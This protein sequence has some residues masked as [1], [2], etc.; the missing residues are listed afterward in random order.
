MG[1]VWKSMGRMT[2][3]AGVILCVFIVAGLVAPQDSRSA[4]L[5]DIPVTV[6]Q[7]DGEELHLLASGDEFNN[8]LHDADHY[9]VLQDL[10]T[11]YYVYAVEGADGDVAPSI[12]QVGKVNPAAVGLKQ[13][14]KRS[15]KKIQERIYER[16]GSVSKGSPLQ[17]QL[18][19]KAPQ[20][21][22]INNLVIF[23]RFSDSPAFSHNI[24]YYKDMFNSNSSGVNSMK[25]YYREA[26][27]NQ[28]AINTTFYPAP[29]GTTIQ[30]YTDSHARNYYQKYHAVTNP[31]GYRNGAQRTT[32]EHTLLKN[33]VEAVRDQV[34]SDLII[35]GDND[36]KVDNVCFIIQGSP[37]GWNELLWPHMWSLYSYD[38]MINNKQ[39]STF[40]F[41][42]ETAT[43]AS[44]VGVLAHEMFHSLGAPD[45]YQYNENAV[46]SPASQWDL[47]D[48][49]LNPPQHMTA[50]M[51]M[52]YGK[53]F[54]SIKP[55]TASGTYT[56]N[57]LTSSTN[58]A[59]RIAS[60]NSSTEYFVLEY[61]KK[62]GTFESSLPNEGLLVSRINTDRR[63]KGNDA[64]N[65]AK[66]IYDELYIYRPGG[67]TGANGT[68]AN[69]TFSAGSGRTS[70]NDGTDP[71]SF[72]SDGSTGGLKISNIGAAGDTISFDV[73]LTNAAQAD[74]KPYQP[75]GWPDKMVMSKKPGTRK[76]NSTFLTS[77]TIYLDCAI[78]NDTA[79]TVT[80]PFWLSLYVDESPVWNW[81]TNSLSGNTHEEWRDLSLG[82]LS[83]GAH[84]IKLVVDTLDSVAETSENDN[85]YTKTI[86][87][88]ETGLPNLVP[89]Q[90]PGWSDK[91]LV[92]NVWGTH[93]DSILYS[94]DKLYVDWAV[95]NKGS[96]DVTEKFTVVLYVDGFKKK[97]WTRNE[98]L[99]A[100]EFLAVGD[101]VLKPLEE[102]LHQI[103]IV[104]DREK[105]VA[106]GTENDNSCIRTIEVE[107]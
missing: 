17:P 59:Y 76:N 62:T 20:K 30:Y 12:Y 24:D 77:D 6:N 47:M 4:P 70:I 1:R 82:E 51:K 2:R 56:L 63:G 90:P 73:E 92:S 31:D 69:A 37:M 46:I 48:T 25:N 81:S 102:G 45:L 89:Y 54:D 87:V 44:G 101:F 39:V 105:A 10:I 29:S 34:P 22:T 33:A 95:I 13:G 16:E 106:E 60:P 28:L 3:C 32:R 38:V 41:Q 5:R 35:D 21:G 103:K 80:N 66:Q 88:K 52:Q 8:W 40:N 79:V 75:S 99:E 94:G 85:T 36:G 71:S 43:D 98:G 84:Q 19:L 61:R 42:L 11:G 93:A 15:P 65:Y 107:K 23:V 49:N 58:N 97:T 57:P 53:W 86:T 27:Y 7:P 100:G 83:A 18:I 9:T 55:I 91:I 50:Y 104:V 72:L 74:L 26:S 78:V 64:A 67:T 96:G 14:V 68:P